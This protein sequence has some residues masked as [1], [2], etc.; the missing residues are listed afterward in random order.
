[1]A[2]RLNL[3]DLAGSKEDTIT[4]DGTESRLLELPPELRNRIYE[5]CPIER[6]RAIVITAAL[7]QPA[8]LSVC[9]L[10]RS[11]ALDVW[12]QCNDFD[13]HIT[14]CDAQLLRSFQK[15]LKHSS[16]PL[17]STKIVDKSGDRPGL[18][19][20]VSGAH[21]EIVLQWAQWAYQRKA[22]GPRRADSAD[23]NTESVV[24][25]IM[26]IAET[27]AKDGLPWVACKTMI[28]GLRDLASRVD[29]R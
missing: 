2:G 7:K 11:E 12:Y 27:A 14:D 16:T 1:M 15:H 10:I 25:A 21:W 13:I 3:G 5:Y 8:M 29:S 4:Q 22:L 28:E 9:R 19:I 17:S 18:A 26:D 6:G 20:T 23:N 24:C